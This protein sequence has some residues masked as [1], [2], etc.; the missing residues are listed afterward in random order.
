M[1]PHECCWKSRC[2][3]TL[4]QCWPDWDLSQLMMCWQLPTSMS[5]MTS[6][7]DQIG[8][9]CRFVNV[10]NFLFGDTCDSVNSSRVVII[11]IIVADYEVPWHLCC[12]PFIM[13]V[14]WMSGCVP[15]IRMTWNLAQK[16]CSSPRHSVKDC[17]F[18]VLKV[19]NQVHRVYILKF[20]NS[21]HLDYYFFTKKY[22]DN[23]NLQYIA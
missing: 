17:W 14:V 18:W 3:H 6:L 2:R 16:Y 5:L 15:L 12:D 4:L 7:K 10:C 1:T 8:S 20:G 11:V 19:K 21:C 22:V 23:I 9:V 13:C